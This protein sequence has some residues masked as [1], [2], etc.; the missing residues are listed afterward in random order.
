MKELPWELLDD[1]RRI[2][3]QIL[4]EGFV[5]YAWSHSIAV[6]LLK[7]GKFP[8]QPSA[9]RFIGL[10]SSLLKLFEHILASK[11]QHC[12]PEPPTSQFG[13]VAGRTTTQLLSTLTSVVCSA[14]S[15]ERLRAR[16]HDQALRG[17][18]LAVAIDFAQAF[19]RVGPSRILE[20]LMSH[21]VP[22]PV[23]TYLARLYGCRYFKVTTPI[24]NSSW[25][26]QRS[27]LI[28]GSVLGP[29]LWQLV[30]APLLTTLEDI[31]SSTQTIP[32]AFADDLVLVFI[33]FSVPS[34]EKRATDTLQVVWQ[35]SDSHCQ[36]ISP[37]KTQCM[38]FSMHPR[39][40]RLELNVEWAC[41]SLSRSLEFLDTAAL[42]PGFAMR[43]DKLI[44]Q[45]GKQQ[46]HVSSVNDVP[47][48][49]MSTCNAAWQVGVNRVCVQP[50]VPTTPTLRILG[51]D[52]EPQ[53]SFSSHVDRVCAEHLK[54]QR[55]VRRL[56]M[57]PSLIYI[58]AA[59]GGSVLY[60]RRPCYCNGSL[61]YS[62]ITYYS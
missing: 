53:L 55:F 10:T 37:S 48:R 27:G 28:Q 52:F 38:L 57:V 24:G 47:V 49:N 15:R 39:E 30:M 50:L 17:K 23:V 45:D 59:E 31:D 54:V 32:L 21:H 61:G 40:T 12:I 4:A 56:G 9:Y 35:W 7:P 34:L 19:D 13:F 62:H 43:R 2:F 11:L 41:H 5:P 3:E 22:A 44:F 25:K 26:R 1:L 51:V 60:S 46:Y 16:G 8:S 42:P 18:A 14:F 29:L 20:Q 58:F 6:P 36:P 33:D